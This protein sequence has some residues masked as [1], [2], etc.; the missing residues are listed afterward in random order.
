MTCRMSG[1]ER[2][3]FTLVELL[4]VIAIIGMLVALLLPAVQAAREAARRMKCTNI[5]KQYGL[6]ISNYLDTHK[7]FPIGNTS[8]N[9][10][11]NGPRCSWQF[12][13]LPYLD[14]APLYNAANLALP[15]ISDLPIS[16]GPF[17]PV[18][19]ANG[20][21]FSDVLLPYA[22]CPSNDFPR[23]CPA[24]SAT[25]DVLDPHVAVTT[26]LG[27][28]GSQNIVS[29]TAACQPYTSFV[30][31]WD[32]APYM[33]DRA[34]GASA[35]EVSGIFGLHCN[36]IRIAEITD[37]T[38]NT[39]LVGEGLPRCNQQQ[40]NTNG[41]DTAWEWWA[42]YTATGTTIVPLNEFSLCPKYGK[43]NFPQCLPTSGNNVNNARQLGRGFK[44]LHVGGVQFTLFR[45]EER[46][47]GKECRSRWSPYH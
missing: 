3:A 47:V 16:G 26:Y 20:Q 22:N 10:A 39:L 28:M 2:A 46:R 29:G 33:K 1:R 6:A 23:D 31:P 12:R 43:G 5:L 4:V 24:K 17:D 7:A 35:S 32:P 15:D 40:T 30:S 36:G 27:S 37:G 25:G 41:G 34:I 14:Q 38:S 11:N 44:S 45:S 42:S 19:Q 13:V 21:T 18:A 9:S 8:N